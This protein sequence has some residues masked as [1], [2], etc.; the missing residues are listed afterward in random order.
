MPLPDKSSKIPNEREV[1]ENLAEEAANLVRECLKESESVR[2]RAF[3]LMMRKLEK[4]ELRTLV[5]EI[6]LQGIKRF[7]PF[8]R[9]P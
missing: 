7:L 9:K 1:A 4:E 6:G 2:K 5:R 3:Q 8:L